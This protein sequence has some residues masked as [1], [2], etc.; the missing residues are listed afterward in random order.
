M[1]SPGDVLRA[2]T[3]LHRER[4][5]S[6]QLSRSGPHDMHAQDAVRLCLRK[7]LD[8][9][10]IVLVRLGSRVGRKG[11]FSDLVLDAL[12]LELLLCLSNPSD[13]GMRVDHR[14][15]YA[16]VYVT[17]ARSNNFGGGDA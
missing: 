4:R 5:R 6:D 8:R 14:G 17:V 13:L 1:T 16:V 7:E 15:N 9:S 2:G 10:F 12:V 11:E 3:V